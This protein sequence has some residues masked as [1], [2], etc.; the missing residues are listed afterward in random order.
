[1]G[2]SAIGDLVLRMV[3]PVLP[4]LGG[5]AVLRLTGLAPAE[6]ARA[7]AGLVPVVPAEA[8]EADAVFEGVALEDTLVAEAV[9]VCFLGGISL[10]LLCCHLAR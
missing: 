4:A 1:M 6:E 8:R 5:G 2:L 3:P 10:L 9:V 7:D